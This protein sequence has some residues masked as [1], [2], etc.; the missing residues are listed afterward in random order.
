MRTRMLIGLIGAHLDPSVQKQEI[1]RF[2]DAH[3]VTL[4]AFLSVG[5]PSS[6]KEDSFRLAIENSQ[7]SPG[8]CVI[9]SELGV[10][11]SDDAEITAS[12]RTLLLE[13]R[14]GIVSILE[15]ID[16]G[17]LTGSVGDSELLMIVRVA[18]LYNDPKKPRNVRGRRLLAIKHVDLVR[19]LDK[20]VSKS[21]IARLLG[22]SRFTVINYIKSNGLGRYMQNRP[23]Q[24]AING[25]N[26]P[27]RRNNGKRSKA[28]EKNGDG[29][30]RNS[31]G[32]KVKISSG[33]SVQKHPGD[34]S[35]DL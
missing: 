13:K 3:G 8:D 26:K 32:G 33:G 30:K 19:H 14:I 25:K 22:V 29:E 5:L 27:L 6:A 15:G 28:H 1:T 7:L 2:A 17:F 18:S 24:F 16:M 11:G 20:G 35:S 9:V 4:A 23:E 34:G 10:L 12:L 31:K 21:A